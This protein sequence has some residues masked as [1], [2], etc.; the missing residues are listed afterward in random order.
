MHR[1]CE[2]CVQAQ[3][4]G[5]ARIDG[6]TLGLQPLVSA[7]SFFSLTYLCSGNDGCDLEERLL[8]S[9]FTGLFTTSSSFLSIRPSL[10]SLFSKSL[11]FPGAHTCTCSVACTH[12][13]LSGLPEMATQTV[14]LET[15]CHEQQ[16]HAPV[17][18]CQETHPH[19]YK[20]PPTHTR[21]LR[22]A[23][24]AIAVQPVPFRPAAMCSNG[25]L[26]PPPVKRPI[27]FFTRDLLF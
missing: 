18:P 4:R 7:C 14:P 17:S 11:L 19:L 23:M 15:C 2:S 3:Y 26:L 13:F 12:L 1:P 5:C 25:T 16:W 20:R 9:V 22:S 8:T 27:P 10:A 24:P 6:S 21:M